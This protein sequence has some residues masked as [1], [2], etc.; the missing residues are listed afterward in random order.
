MEGTPSA[1]KAYDIGP[2]VGNLNFSV[3]ARWLRDAA[4]ES[5][6]FQFQKGL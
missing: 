2:S 6:S 4:A 3:R 1:L 5:F